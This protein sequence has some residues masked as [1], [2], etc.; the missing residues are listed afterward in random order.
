MFQ[1]ASC[2]P[3]LDIIICRV[4][5]K[6]SNILKKC[7]RNRPKLLYDYDI[8]RLCFLDRMKYSYFSRSRDGSVGIVAC[9]V[10]DGWDSIPGK[11]KRSFS[12]S[13]RLR[14]LWGQPALLYN[15][16]HV[17]FLWDKAAGGW[18]WM[19]TKITSS[20]CGLI[21]YLHAKRTL[22]SVI[23]PWL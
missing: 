6:A 4:V 7:A 9:Y 17:M 1:V 19:L 23:T 13:Q 16:Y 14:H 12:T 10:L 3:V 11:A 21:A 15:G 22:L 5:D 8:L 2:C 20:S 18:S